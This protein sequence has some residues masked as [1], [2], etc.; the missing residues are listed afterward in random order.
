MFIDR[1]KLRLVAGRGGNGV[2]AWRREKYIPKGGPAGGNGGNGA[3][4]LLTVDEKLHSL[5]D[6]RN[7]QTIKA[8]NGQQGENNN[9]RGKTGKDLHLKVPLGTLLKDTQTGE[10]LY[11]F[12]KVGDNFKICQGGFGGRGNTSF[13]SST[14]RAPN[15]ATEGTPGEE[16]EIEL[17]LK[18]IADIGLVG[19]PNAGKSTLISKITST[20][21]KIAPYPF[22]TLYPNLG[23]IEFDDFSRLL[24]ADIPGLIENAHLDKG[25]GISFLKHVERTETLVFVID[26]ST[27]DPIQDFTTL[28]EEL[29][30]YDPKLIEK[31]FVIALNKI[32]LPG[33]EKA[34]DLF[35]EKSS[36]DPSLIFKISGKNEENLSSFIKTVRKISQRNGKKF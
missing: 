30:A 14:H 28:R 2:V 31:P 23:F 15:K 24:I 7:K 1:V 6:F 11:D 25:L 35:Y 29:K 8:H 33:A 9:R 36:I 18:M 3:S 12:T 4:I 16:Q 17:E 20:K 34:A 19:M 27:K 13:K 22:T 5:E 32:D 26:L 10:V 21:V